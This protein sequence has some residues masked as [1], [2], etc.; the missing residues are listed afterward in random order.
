MEVLTGGRGAHQTRNI[1][2]ALAK[3]QTTAA[4]PLEGLADVPGLMEAACKSLVGSAR[5]M[6]LEV[7]VDKWGMKGSAAAEIT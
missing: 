3:P 6:G 2:A 4:R 1:I 5:S 7:V